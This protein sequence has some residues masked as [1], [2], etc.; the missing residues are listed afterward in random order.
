MDVGSV[1]SLDANIADEERFHSLKVAETHFYLAL[2]GYFRL[3]ESVLRGVL[4][5]CYKKL[6]FSMFEV[7]QT[8]D[9]HEHHI[10]FPPC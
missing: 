10:S 4:R 8:T 2:G 7:V 3:V 6:S 1:Q 5:Y 9:P